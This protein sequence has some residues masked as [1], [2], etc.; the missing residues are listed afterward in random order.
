MCTG[1]PHV[2]RHQHMWTGRRSSC[3]TLPKKTLCC[4][5]ACCCGRAGGGVNPIW[6]EAFKVGIG[7]TEKSLEIQV[8]AISEC[9]TQGWQDSTCDYG[10]Q[11]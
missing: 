7:S 8:G 4:T 2:L 6:G 5:H 1:T 10:V 3:V 9:E 11:G